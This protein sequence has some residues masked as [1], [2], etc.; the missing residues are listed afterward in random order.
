MLRSSLICFAMLIAAAD[1]VIAQTGPI[2][3][4]GSL[5]SLG[6]NASSLSLSG[7]SVF[8]AGSTEDNGSFTAQCGLKGSSQI[9]LMLGGLSRSETRQ[10]SAGTPSGSW[11]DAR[12]VSHAMA[13]HNLMTPASWFCPAVMLS[14]I[15]SNPTLTVM[16][17]GR[18]SKNGKSVEHVI[19]TV[20][21]VDSTSVQARM[22]SLTQT[23]IFLDSS[24]LLPLA[25]DFNVHPDN[26]AAVNIPVEIRFSNYVESA[27]VWQPATVEKYLNSVLTLKLQ[28]SSATPS[29]ITGS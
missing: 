14:D 18:E 10:T 28:T 3:L 11:T 23:D 19:V 26:D 22:A 7:T 17:V 9:N 8:V 24:S 15:L 29:L 13:G 27:G 20:P 2:L 6:N 5:K 25:L 4:A 12:G 16:Y 21:P 1:P